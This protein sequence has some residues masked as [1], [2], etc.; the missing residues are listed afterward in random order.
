MTVAARP[1]VRQLALLA[2]L[3]ALATGHEAV[4]NTPDDGPLGGDHVVTAQNYEAQGH[5]ASAVYRRRVQAQAN[6]Q[7]LNVWRPLR[8][9]MVYDA[10]DGNDHDRACGGATTG[11]KFLRAYR[12]NDV[13]KGQGNFRDCQGEDDTQECWHS[14]SPAK[15][16]SASDY[17]WIRHLLDTAAAMISNLLAV[18]PVVGPLQLSM[19]A[20][21]PYDLPDI[22][23]TFDDTD[24]VVVVTARNDAGPGTLAYATKLVVDQNSRPLLGYVN[25]NAFQGG[26]VLNRALPAQNIDTAIHEI[27]H[28]MGFSGNMLGKFLDEDLNH[29]QVGQ[30]PRMPP[31]SPRS[32]RT[33]L[34]CTCPSSSK[35]SQQPVTARPPLPPPEHL[36]PRS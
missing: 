8:I 10:L 4:T 26:N 17:A 19:P 1:P 29:R 23:P 16:L 28:A 2:T 3:A 31:P 22:G 24:F 27:F 9:T 13:V 11:A 15:V 12:D 21:R 5:S 18:N 32:R 33:L 30:P 14:C 20:H 6:D 36:R 25:M 34:H 7:N 35:G